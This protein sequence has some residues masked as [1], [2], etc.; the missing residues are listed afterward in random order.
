MDKKEQ[1]FVELSEKE[2]ET[3]VGGSGISFKNDFW[4]KLMDSLC[5]NFNSK[6][7]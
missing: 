2:L 1:T 3:V 4:H 6:K 7:C 5:R